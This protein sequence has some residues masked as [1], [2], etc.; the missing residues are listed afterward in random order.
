MNKIY[1]NISIILTVLTAVYMMSMIFLGISLIG[2][3]TDIIC[4]MLLVYFTFKERYKIETGVVKGIV[5]F[6]NTLYSLII[7]VYFIGAIMSTFY[8]NDSFYFIKVDDRLFNAYV[9]RPFT[10]PPSSDALIIS[11]TSLFYPF[12]ERR[13]WYN[14]KFINFE[15]IETDGTGTKEE[16][17][18]NLK[19]YIQ[20]KI[21]NENTD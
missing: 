11:E 10:L 4:L 9:Y 12:L 17:L 18:D 14:R 7:L 8:R 16:K 19:R 5:C 21:K 3:W 1:K 6:I 2:F 20:Y 13:K 15:V